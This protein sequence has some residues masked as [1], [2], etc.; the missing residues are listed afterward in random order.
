MAPSRSNAKIFKNYSYKNSGI[1]TNEIEELN[2][3]KQDKIPQNIS[4]IKTMR[5]M[6]D[7]PV[8]L[9]GCHTCADRSSDPKTFR[10]QT[11]V[12]LML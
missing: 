3:S 6:A 1:P 9:M 4:L 12:A 10:F 8:D 7:A 11:L 2:G 5:Q